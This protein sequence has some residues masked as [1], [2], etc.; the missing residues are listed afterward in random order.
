MLLAC[1]A[2]V[3]AAFGQ[4]G[5]CEAGLVAVTSPDGRPACV[6]EGSAAVLRERGWAAEAPALPLM[7]PPLR[8]SENFDE[9]AAWAS[10][11]DGGW[12]VPGTP[13]IEIPAQQRG[14]APSEEGSTT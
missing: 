1:A 14:R 4:A 12:R 3:P 13:E 7:V 8:L 5:Q 2:A 11:G 9:F 10:T 6:S